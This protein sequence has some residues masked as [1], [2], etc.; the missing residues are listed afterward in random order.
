MSATA[1]E[2]SQRLR[3]I[4]IAQTA[5]LPVREVLHLAKGDCHL[6]ATLPDTACLTYARALIDTAD[7]HDGYTPSGWT[8]AC[9]CKRCGPVWLWPDAP[10]HVLGCPWC[11]NRAADL[12]IPRPPIRPR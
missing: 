7:R 12:P 10:E 8:Q 5:E 6:L 1:A 3:L 2:E 11:F 9:S 4:R